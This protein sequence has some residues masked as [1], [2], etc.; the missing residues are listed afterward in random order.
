MRK[1]ILK[2]VLL[3][4]VSISALGAVQAPAPALA[5]DE[6]RDGVIEEIIVVSR[7]RAESVRDVPATVAVLTEDTLKA[8]G[9]QRAADFLRMT[10][11]VTLVNAAEVGDTQVNIRGINGARDA[12]NSFAFIVDGILM[13]NPAAFNREFADLQQIEILKGPQGAIYGRN[14]AAGAIIVSTKK[15]GNEFT[16]DAK[17]S[18]GTQESIYG[19]MTLAGPLV[20][21]ELF[22]SAHF[23]YRDTEG[24]FSNSFT[25]EEGTVDQFQNYNISG[26]LLWQP[27]DRTSLDV[28][29]RYGEVDG[30]AIVFNAA[31][32]LVNF[33]SDLGN[34]SAFEDV[35]EH[36]FV[37]QTNIDSDNDQTA[38]EVSA[39]LEHEMAWGTITAWALFSDIENDLIS[40]GTSGAFGFF[41]GDPACQA[42][43]A[44]LAGF[45]LPG[46]GFISGNPVPVL[47]D[48]TGSFLG[49]YTPTTCDGLQEQLRD[50]KDISFELRI[51]SPDNQALRWQAG[52]YFLDIDRQVGVSLGRDDGGVPERGLFQRANIPAGSDRFVDLVDGN[53]TE[54][55]LHDD[56]DSTVFAVFANV[57]YDVSNDVELTLALRYDSEK[58]K[59]TNLVDPTVT[60]QYLDFAGSGTGGSPL[61]PAFLFNPG[62]VSPQERT[63]DELEPKISISWDASDDLTLYAN[64]GVGFKSGGFNNVG[65]AA[66]IDIF[67]NGL[68]TLADPGG[69]FAPVLIEDIFEKETSSAFEVGFKGQLMD[70]RLTYSGALY[71][72][73]V[74]DM[75]SFEFFVGPFGLLRVVNNIDKVRLKGIE[76]GASAQLHEYFSV[77]G[78]FNFTD[79]EIR[80]N[81]SRPDTVGNKSP[82]TAEYT[83]NLAAEFNYPVMDNISIFARADALWVG[84]TWFHAV[85]AQERMTINGFFISG[86]GFFCDQLTAFGAQPAACDA[87]DNGASLG[88]ADFSRAKRDPYMT[89]DVRL[90][91]EGETWSVIAFAKNITKEIYLEEVI[92]APEFGGS[93]IHPAARRTWGVELGFRF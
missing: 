44:A 39:K 15:P 71:Y 37:F 64:W 84:E 49:P 82:Y 48:V 90:G 51:T 12:E 83:V 60:T 79:S 14:A 92:P 4:S 46:P 38:F 28:K 66:T 85:Q 70:G 42:S 87:P 16:V 58:R 80:A 47:V 63:F 57:N 36:E 69:A 93:F 88:I 17:A 76:F 21:D 81:T 68:N 74:D 89:L 86:A 22:F 25:N 5:Q 13:T 59:V 52:V 24:F 1:S 7:R 3:A 53:F 19:S 61:N 40:D 32:A 72:V 45:P 9:V 10:P 31:F 11:G 77:S 67:I 91:L 78:G 56:F 43:A 54:A 8:A 65:S 34:P 30:S 20:Q 2:S 73:D 62:G 50:Q 75:Q 29:A 6:V 18:Y 27:N 55:L 41:A 23:D 35:N 33:A 26:R